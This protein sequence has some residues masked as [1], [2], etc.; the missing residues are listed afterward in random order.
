MKKLLFSFTTLLIFSFSIDSVRAVESSS[1]TDVSDQLTNKINETKTLYN[2]QTT[3]PTNV[4]SRGASIPS[5]TWN[6]WKK[7]Y[8]L[9]GSSSDVLYSSYRL[10]GKG[11]DSYYYVTITNNSTINSVRVM[12]KRESKTYLD[13]TVNRG[14]T[15]TKKFKN[16]YPSTE[17][18][19]RFSSSGNVSVTG[20]V[21]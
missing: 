17:W 16:I 7:D 2:V 3:E 5:K 1:Q 18:Y 9:S 21:K 10:Y 14:S 20:V 8:N 19:L 4:T 15:V 12:C 13:F 6:V 11:D